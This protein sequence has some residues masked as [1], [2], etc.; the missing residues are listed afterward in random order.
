[1]GSQFFIILLKLSFKRP[2]NGPVM[3]VSPELI[4]INSDHPG[5][6][7]ANCMEELIHSKSGVFKVSALP[8]SLDS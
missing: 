8:S 3:I 7:E 2:T 5:S 4:A 6:L 1:M